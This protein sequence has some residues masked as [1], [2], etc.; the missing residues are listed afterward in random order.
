VE[1][2]DA[3]N[4][5]WTR[6]RVSFRASYNNERVPA[7][8]FVPKAG[9]PPY[10]AIV[11][12]PGSDA[13]MKRSSREMGLQFVEFLVR[14]GRLVI[15]PVYQHTFERHIDPRPSGEN[16]LR[17]M[18]L[19]RAQDLRRAVDYLESRP[20]VD[21]SKI[22]GYGLSLGAQL[23]PVFLAVEPRLKTGVL[24]SGGF[25][26]WTIPPEIDPINFAPRVH[27]PVLMVNGREDFD[28]PYTTAQI[29]L[30]KMLG[31]VDKQ[32]VVLEGGHMPPKPQLVYKEILDWLDKHLGPV[33]Q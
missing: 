7:E 8:V 16:A 30:F 24:L 29:P 19:Q 21:R 31:S 26:T 18:G 28:L 13:I 9:H 12:F 25:E 17:Q 27:Q 10:Q 15:F 2:E 33:Q 20:D 22:A 11:F 14:S 23:M 6:Q 4:P 1:S 32:H 3:T 5:N